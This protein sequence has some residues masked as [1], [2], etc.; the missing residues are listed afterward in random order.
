MRKKIN[1]IMIVDDNPADNRYH[2]II[3]EDLGVATHIQV[4]NSGA[5]ALNSLIE[6]SR[7]PPE[8]V[9]LDINMPKM[10]GWE[11]L[12]AYR[13]LDIHLKKEIKIIVLTTSLN[14]EDKE[15]AEKISEVTDFRVKPL[16]EEMLIEIMERYFS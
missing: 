16:T 8:L 1:C 12:E 3:I 11:F 5:D 10:N 6:Y 4:A 13:N 15:K 7:S 9:F 14:E 2:Q